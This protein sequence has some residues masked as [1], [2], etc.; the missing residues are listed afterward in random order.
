M[1]TT[2]IKRWKATEAVLERA[3]LALPQPTG[4]FR[5]EFDRAVG[6]YRH[7]LAHNE[8]GLAFESLRDAAKL[9]PSRGGVWRDLIRAAE[10]MELH[11]EL[12]EL[13]AL[14]EAAATQD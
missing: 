7:F 11:A 2:H 5:A 13:R 6:E 4:Q 8:L 9:V 3:H 10:F 1:E 14:F 12:P